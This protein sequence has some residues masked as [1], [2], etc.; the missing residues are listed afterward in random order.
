MPSRL[1]LTREHY[2]CLSRRGGLELRRKLHR[3]YHLRVAEHDHK[4]QQ[5]GERRLAACRQNVIFRY[6][7]RFVHV[8]GCRCL[9]YL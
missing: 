8:Y 6:N 1:Y 4:Q 5:R 3:V 2:L 9:S 7:C